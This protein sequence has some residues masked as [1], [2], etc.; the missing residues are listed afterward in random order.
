[1]ILKRILILSIIA[2]YTSTLWANDGMWLPILLK[3]Y[4]IEQ[5]QQQGFKLTAEDIYDVNNAC[6]KDAVVGLVRLNNPFRHFCTGNVISNQGLVL[7]NHHCGFGSIQSHSS[8]ENDYL[9]NGFWAQSID[10][11]LSNDNL[12]VCFLKRMEDVTDQVMENITELTGE[13]QRDSIIQANIDSIEHRAVVNTVY[14]AKVKP[15]FSG[16]QY[17]LSVY[18]IFRDVRLVGA[19]PSAIGKFGGD[20]DNWMWPRH[21]GDFSMFR[22]YANKDN[23]PADYSEDNVPYKPINYFKINID[24]IKKGDFTMVMGYPGT[25]NEYLPS[26]AVKMHM[27]VINPTRI[28]IRTRALEIM[29]ADMN[30]NPEVRIKYA[31]KAAGIANGW[32]KW[33]G[34]NKGL[35]LNNAMQVKANSEKDFMTWVNQDESRKAQYGNILAEYKKLYENITPFERAATYFS[36]T[37]FEAELIRYAGSFRKLFDIT[38]ETKPGKADAIKNNLKSRTQTLF[39]DYNLPTDKKLFAAYITFFVND[40]PKEYHPEILS[41][42]DT[43]FKGDINKFTNYIYTKSIFTDSVKVNKLLGSYST[44]DAKKIRKDPVYQLYEQ[45]WLVYL[46]N[47]LPTLRA[48]DSK[49]AKLDRTYMKGLLEFNKDKSLFPDANST[50]RI[51]Y[52]KIDDYIPRDAVQYEYQTTLKGIME[53]D[54][55]EIYDYAVPQKLKELYKNKDYGIYGKNDSVMPVCFLASNHT[56]GGNSGSPVLNANGQLIG[57][58]FDR[59]WEG[60]MSDIIYDPNICRNISLDI[61]YVLFLIDKFAEDHRLVDEMDIV[62]EGKTL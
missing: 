51:A 56:T 25:T 10:E 31:S 61:R 54:N 58:N 30:S 21:T 9:T 12:G 5:M 15:F 49:L 20:T 52:G 43:K 17:F 32:K 14:Q 37:L 45:S 3:K 50:L 27:E 41:L 8:V 19:P 57:I 6:L 53:K 33:I 42:I 60:T 22:I 38:K 26:Y 13:L 36:E 2:F 46:K 62:K 24:G 16:N 11:E 29:K 44:T 18:E 47:I 39:K 4:N 7:T 55:P 23:Q 40:M 59:N 34:E 48:N 1:M 28:N 35:N